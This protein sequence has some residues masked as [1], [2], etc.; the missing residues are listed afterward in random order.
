[1]YYVC[2]RNECLL[3]C[4]VLVSALNVRY[5][6]IVLCTCDITTTKWTYLTIEETVDQTHKY[7]LKY[8]KYYSKTGIP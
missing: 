3:M 4:C 7:T 2:E 6:C 1:M 5:V 8:K